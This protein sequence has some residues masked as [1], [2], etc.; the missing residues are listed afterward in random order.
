MCFQSKWD[1]SIQI[2]NWLQKPSFHE[3]CSTLLGC[4]CIPM[5]WGSVSGLRRGEHED[6]HLVV[7]LGGLSLPLACEV[8][9]L[10]HSLGNN[11]RE[12]GT[13]QHSLPLYPEIWARAVVFTRS[14]PLFGPEGGQKWLQMH[15]CSAAVPISIAFSPAA[16]KKTH[17]WLSE[18]KSLWQGK[19]S[20]KPSCFSAWKLWPN[21]A[22]LEPQRWEAKQPSRAGMCLFLSVNELCFVLLWIPATCWCPRL[23]LPTVQWHGFYSELPSIPKDIIALLCA[24]EVL[25]GKLIWRRKRSQLIDRKCHLLIYFFLLLKMK[26]NIVCV[27]CWNR[28]FNTKPIIAED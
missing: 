8:V 13:P 5:D 28:P 7:H 16:T 10:Q 27:L 1:V 20:T 14:S 12:S 4:Q 25:C 6:L 17:W 11:H 2:P 24:A 18:K 9:P 19:S 23:G 15:L 3:D 22:Y 21:C 26:M